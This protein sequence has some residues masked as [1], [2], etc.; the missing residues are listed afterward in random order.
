MQPDPQRAPFPRAVARPLHFDAVF[1]HDRHFTGK[2]HRRIKSESIRAE[3]DCPPNSSIT[4]PVASPARPKQP[5]HIPG[6]TQLLWLEHARFHVELWCLGDRTNV[7]IHQPYRSNTG[8][9]E[10]GL[11]AV[12]EQFKTRHGDCSQRTGLLFECF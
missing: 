9:E 12:I 7:A 6:K 8:R 5:S 3:P 1:A 10:L 2:G 11:P 4:A